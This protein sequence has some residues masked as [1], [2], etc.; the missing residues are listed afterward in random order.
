MKLIIIIL[1]LMLSALGVSAAEQDYYTFTVDNPTMVDTYFNIFNAMSGLF[2][3]SGYT[4]LLKL[5]F[6]MGGFFTF[7]LAVFKA[8]SDQSGLVKEFPKYMLTTT[9]ILIILFSS[10]A[11]VLITTNKIPSYCNT[12]AHNTQTTNVVVGNIPKV[13]AWF[14]SGVN[15]FS[16]QAVKLTTTAYSDVNMA[17]ITTSRSDYAYF[18]TNIK[19]IISMDLNKLSSNSQFTTDMSIGQ[20]F[21]RIVSE[22]VM[23]PANASNEFKSKIL[24]AFYT[25]G[26]IHETMDQYILNSKAVI[27]KNPLTYESISIYENIH[28]NGIRPGDLLTVSSSGTQ[29]CATSWLDFKERLVAI[30]D[31]GAIECYGNLADNFDVNTLAIFTGLGLAPTDNVLGKMKS[32]SIN[33]A[34]TNSITSFG[35]TMVASEF[36][37]AA[38][39][40]MSET[41]I[42]SV[43]SGKF[44][45]EMLPVL[46]S[47]LRAILYAFFPFVFIIVILPG[48]IKVLGA[49]LKTIIWVELWAPAM[50][51]LNMFM[52]YISENKFSE[53]FESGGFNAMSGTL[54]YSDTFMLAG[55]AGYLFAF[56]PPLTWLLLEGSA[57]MLGNMTEG[58]SARM[59]GNMQSDAI[60]RDKADMVRTDTINQSR[61]EERKEAI[62]MAEVENTS[63]KMEG[64]SGAGEWQ[65]NR[66]RTTRIEEAAKG[67][68]LKKISNG[69]ASNNVLSDPEKFNNISNMKELELNTKSKTAEL[70]NLG[71]KGQMKKFSEAGGIANATK[72][73]SEQKSQE[74]IATSLGTKSSNELIEKMSDVKSL[75]NLEKMVKEDTKQKT[76]GKMSPE[77]TIEESIS[78]YAK[79]S[80]VNKV[81]KLEEELQFQDKVLK[82]DMDEIKNVA[83][84]K[85][86]EEFIKTESSRIIQGSM[87]SESITDANV[88][89][90][91][92]RLGDA[93]GIEDRLKSFISGANAEGAN[94]SYKNITQASKDIASIGS[95]SSG[96][97]LQAGDNA[98]RNFHNKGGTLT[99]YKDYENSDFLNTIATKNKEFELYGQ[100]KGQD[101]RLHSYKHME[102][103]VEK[104]NMNRYDKAVQASLTTKLLNSD[105]QTYNTISGNSS[106]NT[107]NEFG[108][109]PNAKG[110]VE[111][112]KSASKT[113]Y[114]SFLSK[115]LDTNEV[116]EKLIEKMNEA[117]N[118]SYAKFAGNMIGVDIGE[119]MGKLKEKSNVNLYNKDGTRKAVSARNYSY[120]LIARELAMLTNMAMSVVDSLFGDIDPDNR[121]RLKESIKSGMDAKDEKVR[122]ASLKSEKAKIGKVFGEN[123]NRLK[124][125]LNAKTEKLNIELE[126]NKKN[127]EKLIEDDKNTVKSNLTNEEKEANKKK[128][129]EAKEKVSNVNRKKAN[130][131]NEFGVLTGKM[132][133]EMFGSINDKINTSTKKLNELKETQRMSSRHYSID[134]NGN[135]ESKN[136]KGN[137]FQRQNQKNLREFEKHINMLEGKTNSKDVSLLNKMT[138]FNQDEINRLKSGV[139]TEA[140]RAK[141]KELESIGSKLSSQK[142][143]IINAE[144]LKNI[145]KI[146]KEQHKKSLTGRVNQLITIGAVAYESHSIYTQIKEGKLV[147]DIME[148]H[149]KRE[150]DGTIDN[151]GTGLAVASTAALLLPFAGLFIR[152]ALVGIEY[153]YD[154]YKKEESFGLKSLQTSGKLAGDDF[155][156]LSKL[157]GQGGMAA[158]SYLRDPIDFDPTRE[159]RAMSLESNSM[160][161]LARS[162][163]TGRLGEIK[164]KDGS[165]YSIGINR[166]TENKYSIDILNKNGDVIS[167]FETNKLTDA[168]FSKDG[169][170]SNMINNVSNAKNFNGSLG[171]INEYGKIDQIKS[172]FEGAVVNA[173]TTNEYGSQTIGKVNEKINEWFK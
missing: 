50:S 160:S 46:Q 158:I 166:D 130:L 27:F 100:M 135:I 89:K 96:A 12:E 66:E 146:V 120:I 164:I 137:I 159:A 154:G 83:E 123:V 38:G 33:S 21:E 61:N 110:K 3:S 59:S 30:R 29:S 85:A 141:I 132:R 16:N 19:E 122:N 94:L 5:V 58:I 162:E 152:G 173:Q 56:I 1:A 64:R 6:L 40:S 24:D 139:S 118:S 73:L 155:T 31:S 131:R 68:E 15:T 52:S 41:A 102:N 76:M 104:K 36:K 171:D 2:N 39:K 116:Q 20:A 55:V 108:I 93:F 78:D 72:T 150:K 23:L 70:L 105:K 34:L 151:F 60:N 163:E 111:G 142:T 149:I 8:F 98:T 75:S 63:A 7:V 71:D 127:L 22:C 153:L 53:I 10:K 81:M 11:N 109:T 79:S 157:A 165:T 129:A 124:D 17:P 107:L 47:G 126:Q 170:M 4:Q 84:V 26:D 13:L 143:K 28:I 168:D 148:A 32:I 91:S 106:I 67:N 161:K 136:I 49:Y 101:L 99:N 92:E 35:S 172:Q 128:I 144:A 167:N 14:F 138:A 87:S 97:M 88:A 48:G 82:G 65:A 113:V 95:L 86:N 90:Q 69:I 18:L 51:V 145:D 45:A 169:F 80:S 44:M 25:S 121:K 147:D 117:G 37:Y 43:G 125:K 62:S 74:A 115:A 9:A 133:Q 112:F 156:A 103:T 54:I 57:D 134:K 119:A 42:S 140:T 114:G 77:K